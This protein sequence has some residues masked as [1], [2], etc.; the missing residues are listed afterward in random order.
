MSTKPPTLTDVAK[1]AGVS[2]STVS[3]VVEDSTK[4]TA[5]TRDKVKAAMQEIGY[6]GNAAARQLVSGSSSTIGIITSSTSHYGYS[7][8]IEGIEAEARKAGT[9]TLIAVADNESD[10]AVRQAISIVVS[11]NP[12]GVLILDFD[13]IGS[14]VLGA[15]PKHLATVA[16]T[17]A[18]RTNPEVVSIC[19]DDYA[20]GYNLG[21]HLISQGHRSIFMI[22]PNDFPQQGTRSDGV[23]KAL[24][25]ARL[26]QYPSFQADDW[27]PASGYKVATEILENYGERVTAIICGNDELAVGAMRAI[28]EKNLRVPQDVSCAGFDDHHVSAYLPTALTTIRQDFKQLGTNAYQLLTEVI[29]DK[30]APP[31]MTV[32]EPTL[33]ARESTGEAN[34]NRGF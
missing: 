23:A 34:L 19:I 6:Y 27:F 24:R 32:I 17:S 3:R 18:G 26:P 12:A 8:T 15:I 21:K 33:I 4:V 2:L 28:A 9:A 11:Q 14:A 30:E 10:E 13:D 25:E 29:T 22:G 31:K 16:V 1:F 7:R 20:G 5:A